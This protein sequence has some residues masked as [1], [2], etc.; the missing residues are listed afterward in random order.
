[1]R[2]CILAIMLAA[3][4]FACDPYDPD[5]GDT[6][7]RCGTGA[8]LCPEGYVCVERSPAERL[9][10]RPDEPG[11]GPDGGD[12]TSCGDDNGEEP[13]ESYNDPSTTPIPDFQ[14]EY[15]VQGF[16]IC[17]ETDVD[18]YR[19]RVNQVGRNVKV[20]VMYTASMGGLQVD[21][22]NEGGNSIRTGE[23]VG[24][25]MDLLRAEIPNLPTGTY[26]AQIRATANMRN[27]YDMTISLTGP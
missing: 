14:S 25:N 8:P 3:T 26:F 20:E 27:S 12:N 7:F 6:P 24:G 9:C 10:V 17:P 19:F 23:P 1:M 4:A 18:T 15:T 16:A 11:D 22:L 5:L 2:A 21:V 13:N